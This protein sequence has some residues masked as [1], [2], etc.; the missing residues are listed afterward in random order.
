LA[1]VS[2]AEGAG[3]GGGSIAE[4]QWSVMQLAA[5]GVAAAWRLGWWGVLRG[6]LSVLEA[7]GLSAGGRPLPTADQWEVSCFTPGSTTHLLCQHRHNLVYIHR[8]HTF[9]YSECA[10]DRLQDCHWRPWPSPP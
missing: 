8:F 10:G 2:A 3:G 1:A 6:Y 4:V 9:I 5:L 7:V